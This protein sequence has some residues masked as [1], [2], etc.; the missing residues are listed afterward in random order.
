MKVSPAE[1]MILMMLCDVYEKLGIEGEID[2]DFVR[3]ALNSDQLWAFE[4]NYNFLNDINL[5]HENPAVV[6]EVVDILDMWSFL[7]SAFKQ[8][9]EDEKQRVITEGGVFGDTIEFAGFD[10]NNED[11]YSV[12]VFM[13]KDLRR[14]QHFGGRELNSHSE[15]VQGY[16][17]MLEVF[18]PMR[19]GIHMGKMTADQVIA[20]MKARRFA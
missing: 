6:K 14:F 9:G 16:K 13:I 5:P 15:S 8:L 11:H 7:E 17:R 20:V 12:A 18:L 4:W 10:A 2:H 3:S 1:K 19:P